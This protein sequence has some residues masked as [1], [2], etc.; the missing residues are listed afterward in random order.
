M[1]APDGLKEYARS[2]A[3]EV[4]TCN[5]SDSILLGSLVGKTFAVAVK[6]CLAFGVHIIGVAH[7][8]P[9]SGEIGE[10]TLVPHHESIIVRLTLST[11][12][13]FLRQLLT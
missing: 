12:L 8:E 13:L 4:F 3:N 7:V 9:A 2:A 1:E 10:M 6:E 11:W 5:A